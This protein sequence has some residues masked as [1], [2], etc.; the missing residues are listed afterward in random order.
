MQNQTYVVTVYLFFFHSGK[1][2]RTWK[3]NWVRREVKGLFC[4]S[5]RR[6]ESWLLARSVVN[7]WF[8]FSRRKWTVWE[9]SHSAELL[10][11]FE[12]QTVAVWISKWTRTGTRRTMSRGEDGSGSNHCKENFSWSWTCTGLLKILNWCLLWRLYNQCQHIPFLIWPLVL[13]LCI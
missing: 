2:L 13:R 5:V 6:V 4:R 9:W 8:V 11:D 10:T 7:K 1:I 12:I 3:K